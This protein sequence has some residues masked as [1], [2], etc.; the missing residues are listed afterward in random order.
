MLEIVGTE[1]ALSVDRAHTP[2]PEDVAIT[3]R[4]RDGRV[5]EMVAGGA[6][7]YRAMIDHFQAVVRGGV[8]PRRSSADS[9]ALLT[10]L[11]R[12]REAAGLAAPAGWPD[13]SGTE[14]SRQTPRRHLPQQVGRLR[15]A[16]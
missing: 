11:D 8:E 9:V 12:L 15:F 14:H 6:D 5:E 2:G 3:L 10:V 1:A 16:R 4:H 7:P 13:R